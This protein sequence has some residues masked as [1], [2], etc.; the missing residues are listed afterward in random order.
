[1]TVFFR[2]YGPYI[3]D[4]ISAVMQG[5][6]SD[7]HRP[8]MTTL[9]LQDLFWNTGLLFARVMAPLFGIVMLLG[10]VTNVGQGGLVFSTHQIKPQFTRINP[11]SGAKRILSK[12]GAFDTVKSIIKLAV[13]GAVAY[14]VIKESVV[15]FATL[16]G[17][18]PVNVGKTLASSMSDLALRASGAYFI[19]ACLDFGYQRWEHEQKMKMTLQ[20]VKEEMRSTEGNPEIKSRIRRIQRQMA[21]GRMMQDVSSATVVVTNPTHIAVAI[22][23][24][25]Q[26]M[27]AP[28]VVAK[29]TG[30]NAE[31]IKQKAREHGI[32]VME[33]KPLARGLYK[34]ADVG[35][36]IP[37]Q[38]YEAVA[39]VIAY[40]YRLRT[41]R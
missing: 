37:I 32:L 17:A 19:L 36:E 16:T 9:V 5:T 3:F 24:D 1:V 40:V 35:A 27:P 26:T 39:D 12:R 41:R 11:A 38:L 34:L 14:P 15:G 33:N 2:W 23:F 30:K 22:K 13:V 10:V 7:L 4:H 18:D 6:F 8:D 28:I 25:F 20:E 31:R 21:R 29:G